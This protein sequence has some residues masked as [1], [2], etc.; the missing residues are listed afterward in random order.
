[1]KKLFTLCFIISLGGV[2]NAQPNNITLLGHLSYGNQSCA[3]V[4]HYVGTGGNEYA[5][6][7]ASDR[8]SIVDVTTP[9][10]PVEVASVPALPGQSSLWREVKTYGNYAYAVSEGGGGVTIVDLSALPAVTSKHWYGD[11]ASSVLFNSA[12]AIAA[13]DGYLYIFGSSY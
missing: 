7:G 12:H 9:A 11:T 8:L 4:W 5:I 10:T 3:G 13:T 6:V 2:L 1:M